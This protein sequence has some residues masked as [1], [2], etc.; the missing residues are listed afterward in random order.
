MK[1]QK[2]Q[3]RP[4][5]GQRWYEK[6]L[7][8]ITQEEN[9]RWSVI[10]MISYAGILVLGGY[11]SANIMNR[12]DIVGAVIKVW[13]GFFPVVIVVVMINPWSGG[14]GVQAEKKLQGPIKEYLRIHGYS[15][16]NELV[17]HCMPLKIH[18]GIDWTL[19]SMLQHR[20]LILEEDGRYRLPTDEDRKNWREED[21]AELKCLQF[22]IQSFLD[23]IKTAGIFLLLPP[24][25]STMDIEI[26]CS[27]L[28]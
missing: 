15:T 10:G 2:K 6:V 21:L 23:C 16:Y 14:W 4:I 18:L 8:W 1:R 20:E 19:E 22:F 11:I 9:F 25:Y 24:L 5:A 13:F 27:R 3:Y 12:P 17:A 28:Q 7:G 26:S